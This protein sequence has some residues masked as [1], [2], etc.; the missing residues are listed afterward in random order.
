MIIKGGLV[1]RFLVRCLGVPIVLAAAFAA[2]PH[3]AAAQALPSAPSDQ[4]KPE[5][6]L[7]NLQQKANK[8]DAAAQFYLGFMYENGRGVPQNYATHQQA[9]D[10]TAPEDFASVKIT[11]D[12]RAPS[13][14]DTCI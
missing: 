13:R 12:R 10:M 1:M 6:A 9:E 7:A 4:Q 14:Q 2:T 5:A 11:L 8:G 3:I